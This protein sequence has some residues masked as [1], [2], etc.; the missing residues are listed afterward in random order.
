MAEKKSSRL[1]TGLSA[2]FGEEKESIEEK[3]T[4]TLPIS[5]VEPRR[6]QPRRQ[7]DA[8]SLAALADSIREYGLLQPITVRP[9][10][11]GYYQIIAGER[12]WRAARE[13]GLTEVPVHILEADDRLAMELALVENLQR[14]DLNPMEEAA[15]YQKLM[16]EYGLTQ[17]EVA[18]RVQKSR[19]AVANALR[20]LGLGKT[21]GK[22]VTDGELSAGHARALLPLKDETLQAKA[23]A[24]VVARGLSVRQTEALTASLL[25]NG[26]EAPPETVSDKPTVNYVREAEKRLTDSLGRGV[27][28]VGG[29]KKGRIQLEFY[30]PDDREALMEALMKMEKPWKSGNSILG[31]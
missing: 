19:P 2:L 8:E 1:G 10:E 5:R 3:A 11:Q 4:Q 14:E 15:G 20:L 16:E 27:R 31:E 17:E 7:F 22:M 24:Q 23:A 21:V 12:R 9:L 29:Q 28:F 6:D 25:K 18:A 26:G 13:A 30:S